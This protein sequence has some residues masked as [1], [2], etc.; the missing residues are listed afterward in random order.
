MNTRMADNVLPALGNP[1]AGLRAQPGRQTAALEVAAVGFG[2]R[3]HDAGSEA[4]RA[5][6]HSLK[7]KQGGA[8]AAAPV[9]EYW[10]AKLGITTA[11]AAP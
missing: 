10:A 6:R 1:G 2:V 4:H 9:R 5:F 11:A 7:S 3:S 8:V